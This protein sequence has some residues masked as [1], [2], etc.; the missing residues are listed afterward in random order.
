[1]DYKELDNILSDAVNDSELCCDDIPSIA[2]YLDQIVNLISAKS[3]EGA[4][5]FYDRTLTKT[6]VNNYSKAGMI[7]PI[8][9]KKY[10]KEQIV[11]MLMINSLKNT[12]SISEIKGAMDAFYAIDGVD[13]D[14]LM[15]VYDSYIEL[16]HKAKVACTESTKSMIELNDFNIENKIDY[17][18][19]V[20][21]VV[22]MAD[23]FNCIAHAMLENILPQK[24]ADEETD[25][26]E[27]PKQIEREVKK[28]AKAVK[29]E[30]KKEYKAQKK[31]DSTKNDKPPVPSTDA[32]IED[33]L[34][35][36]EAEVD[37]ALR[38]DQASTE[39]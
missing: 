39:D 12:F 8:T 35:L 19:A 32:S 11:Q 17:L 5:R 36:I 37:R 34:S 31:S 14:T 2:L 28:G 26:Y 16:R 27:V 3:H 9:G 18:K 10:S 38:S 15:E 4:P 20:L 29:K 25:E 6:M 24:A 1:M 7:T 30:A 22:A 21:G 23:Y 33:E 13:G